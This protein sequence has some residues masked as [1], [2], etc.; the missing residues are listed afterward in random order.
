MASDLFPDMLTAGAA[1]VAGAK[2]VVGGKVGHG[3][4]L[5]HPRGN[6]QD[7]VFAEL[8]AL[9]LKLV[10][11]RGIAGHLCALATDNADLFDRPRRR[12]KKN[13]NCFGGDSCVFVLPESCS[14]TDEH[15]SCSADFLTTL[16]H[17]ERLPG[18]AGRPRVEKD[19]LGARPNKSQSTLVT[20]T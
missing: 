11:N 12:L 16:S 14:S 2:R 8:G 15:G 4:V 5:P 20:H 13:L 10:V 3:C 18:V 9:A 6:D 1:K 19:G 17:L 7:S